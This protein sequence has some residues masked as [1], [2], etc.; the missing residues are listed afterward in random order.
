MATHTATASLQRRTLGVFS[1]NVVVLAIGYVASILLA[2]FLGADGRGLI[3]VIQTGASVI[4][5]L[6]GIGTQNAATYYASRRPRRRAY[7]LGNGL[8]HAGVLLV[9]SVAV[10]FVLMGELQQRVAPGYDA[11]IWLLA[12]LLV[13][14]FYLDVL[15][16]NLLSAQSSFRL[17]QPAQRGR[18]HRHGGRDRRHRRLA[19]LGR[20]RRHHRHGSD[21]AWCRPW[22]VSACSRA[23]ASRSRARSRR[24][25]CATAPASRS[26]PCC[27]SS[28]RAST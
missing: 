11:R 24:P 10:A 5:G 1:T 16:S 21:P 15:V 6:G 7:V 19:R 17:A 14:T 23:T 20:R 3:A 18:A 12:A 2:R 25:R 4:A 27:T 22:A 13:P 26:A 8:A 28:T 9:V